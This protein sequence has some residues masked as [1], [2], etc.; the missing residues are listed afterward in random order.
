[1]PANIEPRAESGSA[2]LSEREVEILRLVASGA[3]NKEIAARLT[4]SPNTVKVHVR[5]IFGKIGVQ[6]RT[7][8]ALYAIQHGYVEVPGV[9]QPVIPEEAAD[10]VPEPVVPAPLTD[11]PVPITTSAPRAWLMPAL[12]IGALVVFGIAVWRLLVAPGP[13]IASAATPTS[14]TRWSSLAGLPEPLSAPSVAVYENQIVVIGGQ[15]SDGPSANVWMFDTADRS[16]APGTTKP[17]AVTDA[18]AVLIGGR[19]YVPGGR[20]VDGRP[21]DVLEIYNPRTDAWETGAEL[22][23]PRSGHALVALDG[24]LL[25]FGGWDGSAF[26]ASV[27]EYTPEEDR[28]QALNDMPTARGF[29]AAAVVAGRVFVIGGTDGRG[30]LDANEAY[31]PEAEAEENGGWSAAAPMPTPGAYVNA[32]VV[33]DTIFVFGGDEQDKTSI[34]LGYSAAEDVWAELEAAPAD[35][36]AVRVGVAAIGPVVH[37]LGGQ[38][39]AQPETGHATYQALYVS[40]IPFVE[41]GDR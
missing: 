18:Q 21:V 22:P 14:P 20:D 25:L 33:A 30:P 28:W 37:L 13:F 32:A 38:R 23:A 5:N 24:R 1:M 2:P 15:G 39:E 31:T 8:A 27:F 17:T 26:S 11:A 12:L 40:F 7:E 9:T 10:E 4:I 35:S 16:W 19:I 36:E 34:R 41:S 3:S 6:S 29:A